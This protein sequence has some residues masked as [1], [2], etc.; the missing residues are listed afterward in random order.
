MR[1][2]N[3]AEIL[4]IESRILRIYLKNKFESLKGDNP[5][6]TLEIINNVHSEIESGQFGKYLSHFGITVSLD[7]SKKVI[8]HKLKKPDKFKHKKSKGSFIKTIYTAF[9]IKRSRH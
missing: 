8:I 4:G 9:E 1:L 2:E 3:F 7:G 5:I 6:L